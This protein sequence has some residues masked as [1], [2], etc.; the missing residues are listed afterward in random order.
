MRVITKNIKNNLPIHL[1]RLIWDFYDESYDSIERDDYQFFQIE[2]IDN[3]TLLKMWQ[4]EPPAK[5][6]KVVPR[7]DDIEVWII[8]DGNVTTMLFPEDY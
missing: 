7:F 3:H 5:K 8:D 4:E 2:S 6:I 1:I